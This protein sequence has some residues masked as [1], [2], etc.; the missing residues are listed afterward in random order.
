MY[1]KFFQDELTKMIKISHG[2]I[3]LFTKRKRGHTFNRSAYNIKLR[4]KHYTTRSFT[5][6]LSLVYHCVVRGSRAGKLIYPKSNIFL[7]NA[8]ENT[9]ARR[10][11]KVT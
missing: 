7:K 11:F 8:I 1:R 3:K 6:V 9:M 10:K 5:A 4:K 2:L